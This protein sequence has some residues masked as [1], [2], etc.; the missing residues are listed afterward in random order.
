MG[1]DIHADL[2]GGE[3]VLDGLARGAAD[4]GA[5]AGQQLGQAEGLGDVVVG[6]RIQTDDEIG[7]LAAGGEHEDGGGQ[8]L[9]AHLT[10]DIEPVDIGQAEI[11]HDDVG[12]GDLLESTLAGAVGAH[13]VALAPEGASEG[14]GDG[15]IVLNEKHC[16]HRSDRR[17][18]KAPPPSFARW[19]HGDRISAQA[20]ES[21]QGVMLPKP[22]ATT[23]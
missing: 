17:R 13:L 16:R 2:T 5:H 15:G 12:A 21:S 1:G 6:T 18:P 7:V 14:L 8:T 11:Q 3:L 4:L 19:R 23:S 22:L 10:G 20:R 9:S